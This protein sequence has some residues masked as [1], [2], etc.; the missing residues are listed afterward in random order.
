MNKNVKSFTSY[1]YRKNVTVPLNSVT[2]DDHQLAAKVNT[3]SIDMDKN[4]KSFTSYH[5]RKNVTVPINSV[6][7]DYHR[8]NR[9]TV[10]VV[11]DPI[12]EVVSSSSNMN[13]NIIIKPF[14]SYHNRS[15][16]KVEPIAEASSS[17]TNMN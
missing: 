11:P 3:L 17:S 6:T 12:V 14:T 2:N 5:Y 16:N 15:Y 10:K 8:L 7:P 13:K 1:Q 4:I 9:I